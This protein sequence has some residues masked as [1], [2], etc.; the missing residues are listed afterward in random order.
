MDNIE[1]YMRERE[2]KRILDLLDAGWSIKK[3]W[4]LY[5]L[6]LKKW[7]NIFPIC[8]SPIVV[9]KFERNLTAGV[10]VGK[11]LPKDFYV[12]GLYS[13]MNSRSKHNIDRLVVYGDLTYEWAPEEGSS[14]LYLNILERDK[15]ITN[16]L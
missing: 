8:P 11:D 10:S 14:S 13:I 1:D 6:D 4:M 15:K 2:R 12:P 7:K 9:W 3:I 5:N 16:L